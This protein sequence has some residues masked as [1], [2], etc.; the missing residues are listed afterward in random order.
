M[1]SIGFNGLVSS[2]SRKLKKICN[3]ISSYKDRWFIDFAW[4][5]WE[6]FHLLYALRYDLATFEHF[7]QEYFAKSRYTLIFI[8][9]TLV[10]FNYLEA[11]FDRDITLFTHFFKRKDETGWWRFGSCDFFDVLKV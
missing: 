9:Y 2:F 7:L 3:L 11:V 8:Q 5:D 6:L 4:D 1:A 10:T